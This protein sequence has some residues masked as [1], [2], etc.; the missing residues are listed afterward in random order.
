MEPAAM[1]RPVLLLLATALSWPALAAPVPLEPD[2]VSGARSDYNLSTRG[3]YRVFARSDA[4][5]AA[6]HIHESVRRDGRWSVPVPVAFSDPRWRDSDPWLTPDGRTLYFI[7][8]RPTASRPDKRDLDLW[9]ATRGANGW[10]APEH[11]GDAVNSAGAELGPELHR[12]VLYFASS[13][14]GGRGGLDLYAAPVDGTG[15][16]AAQALPAPLN[17]AASESDLT[18]SADGRS[19][20]FWRA[21]DGR[22]LLHHARRTRQG[23]NVP[24]PLPADANP[25]PMQITPA[26]AVDGR[27]LVFASDLQRDGQPAGLFDLYQVAWPVR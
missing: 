12:G 18:F 11:L 14:T 22:L 8:D 4:D 7:S 16:G 10:S 3:D 9:R 2:A 6:A 23:W 1:R 25:G 21:V 24:T 17:S 20:V 27:S 26:F 5:F 19:A 15:F 13:R